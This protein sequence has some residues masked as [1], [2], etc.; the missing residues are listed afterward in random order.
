M[1]KYYFHN[2]KLTNENKSKKKLPQSLN[3]DIKSVVD[4]NILLNKVKIDEKNQIK[5]KIIFFSLVIT[6]L[7]LFGTFITFL[8]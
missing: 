7:I 3:I 6:I 1:Q 8:K 2:G 5:R 4:I